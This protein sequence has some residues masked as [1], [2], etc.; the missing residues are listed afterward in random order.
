MDGD[1]MFGVLVTAVFLA[2]ISARGAT[3]RT[4]SATTGFAYNAFEVRM[5]DVPGTRDW[6]VTYRQDWEILTQD[7]ALRGRL[8]AQ[9]VLDLVA[10]LGHPSHSVFG[11][12][13]PVLAYTARERQLH[14]REDA[15]PVWIPTPERFQQE[16]ET[17]RRIA[18][19]N[20]RVGAV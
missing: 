4:G 16:L 20:A 13:L 19:I 7:T 11:A 14:S 12:G 18:E 10:S 1:L 6:S 9:G 15:G 17:L 5:L 3:G 2:L 8:Q